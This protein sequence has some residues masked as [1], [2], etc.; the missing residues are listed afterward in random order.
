MRKALAVL[1]LFLL[2]IQASA[3]EV[4]HWFS[5]LDVDNGTQAFGVLL[6]Q[7]GNPFG[8][9]QAG[10]GKI[11]TTG[12]ATAVAAVDAAGTDPFGPIAVGD[13]LVVDRGNG[14]TDL[15]TVAARTDADNV[16]VDTNINWDN[17]GAGFTFRWY[18]ATSCTDTTCGWVD[19]SRFETMI[20]EVGLERSDLATGILFTIECRG[21][22]LGA[23]NK[24]VY[25]TT[26]GTTQALT[27]ANAGTL[28]GRF[29]VE[30][31]NAGYQACRLG[32]ARNGADT[33]DV[34]NASTELFDASVTGGTLRSN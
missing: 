14:T 31:N 19:V 12:S 22:G 13:L 8:G 25:P 30:F 9:P 6:G 28:A 23:T 1:L 2:P 18:R 3:S 27:T 5:R 11:K 20:V 15:R 33:A 10:T 32:V 34:V 29:V 21:A 4:A 24:Q 26:A 16:T 17:A 7:N